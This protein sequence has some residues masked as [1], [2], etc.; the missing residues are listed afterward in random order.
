M[1]GRYT[2]LFSPDLTGRCEACAQAK[3]WQWIHT[4]SLHH[5]DAD[6]FGTSV[7]PSR[8][9]HFPLARPP[10]DHPPG[11][12]AQLV[13]DYEQKSDAPGAGNNELATEQRGQWPQERG[14]S[15]DIQSHQTESDAYPLGYAI[16]Q[17]HGVYILAQNSR[18]WS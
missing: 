17:L 1:L 6:A 14:R 8:Q 2:T 4:V 3:S 9:H 5:P 13:G 10:N 7:S 18:A 11:G 16:A 12:L 15:S